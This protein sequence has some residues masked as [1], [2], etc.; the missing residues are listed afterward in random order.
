MPDPLLGVAVLAGA[1]LAG[2]LWLTIA[3]LLPRS[4]R[5]DDALLSLENPQ[6]IRH[7]EEAGPSLVADTSSRLELAGAWC[8]QH[9]RL[10]LPAATARALSLQG[11]SIGDYIVNKLVLAVGGLVLPSLLAFALRPLT[12]SVGGLPVA[13]GIVSGL[14]GWFWPDIALRNQQRQAN[15]DAEEALNSFFDLVVLERLANL[16]AAQALEAAARL[17]DVPVFVQ[18]RG[19]LE[20]A[21]LEQRPPWP[22]LHRLA[23]D[24]DLQPIADIADVM[25]LDNQGAS[26][27]EVLASRARELRDAHLGRERTRAHEASERMTLW[28]SIPVLI[29]ALAFLVPPLLTMAGSG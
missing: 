28:M 14:L 29:F 2:G 24:L 13:A 20:R 21:R 3:A 16:S 12:G 10:P 18:I 15:S 8:Y 7:A 1:I 25:Q 6:A 22:D 19:A 5:L 23:K 4:I 26:L 11:R 9:G 27:A 17:S